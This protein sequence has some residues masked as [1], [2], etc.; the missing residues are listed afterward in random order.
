[1]ENFKLL[2]WNIYFKI[3]ELMIPGVKDTTN[4]INRIN[5]YLENENPDILFVQESQFDLSKLI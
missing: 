4:K 1:M 3:G 5:K 2:S